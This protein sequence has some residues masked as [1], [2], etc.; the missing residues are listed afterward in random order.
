M[1]AIIRNRALC[2]SCIC[3]FFIG[4]LSRNRAAVGMDVS[5]S[6]RLYS[7]VRMSETTQIHVGARTTKD[8]AGKAC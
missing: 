2:H 8:P 4:A 3:M 5:D 6:G 7:R 1:L